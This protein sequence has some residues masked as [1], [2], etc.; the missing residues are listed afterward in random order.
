MN[1]TQP[2]LLLGGRFCT[3]DPGRPWAEAVVIRGDRIAFVGGEADAR[4]VAGPNAA[5]RRMGGR[6]VLPGL[7]DA[8]THPGLVTGSRDVFRLPVGG[9]P[10]EVVEAVAEAAA[11]HPDS[12]ALFGGYWPI[13]AFGLDGPRRELLDA[14]VPDRPVILFDDSGHSQWCNSAALRALGI[15]AS[16]P[17]PAPGLSEFKRDPGGWPTGWTKEFSLQARLGRL[18]FNQAA[19]PAELLAFLEDLVGCGVVALLDGGSQDAEPAVYAALADLDREGRLPLRYEGAVHVTQ[20][21]QLPGVVSRLDDLRRRVAG[22]RLRIDTVKLVL[23]GVTEVGTAA[24][25][26]PY[27]DGPASSG[28]TLVDGATLEEL[29]LALHRRAANLH[30]HTVG[31][32][33]VRLALDATER[34]QAAV[35]GRLAGTVTLSHIEVI[36]PADLPRFA[37][38]G[39]VAN[40]TPH[41]YGGYFHGAE[42]W[43]GAER[44]E[45]MYQVRT[46]TE[47]GATVA[48]SS[49]I[50]DHAEW[51]AGRANPFLGMQIGHTRREPGAPG[52]PRPR[53]E[54]GASREDLVRGYTLH[55]ARQLG[56]EA[57]LG[58]IAPCKRADLVVLDRDVFTI[59]AEE[60]HA[61]RPV[62]VLLAGQVVRGSLD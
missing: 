25:L 37:A 57:E 17:D 15:D 12:R 22:D 5:V 30:L 56:L 9:T 51:T 18:G 1:P 52:P 16:T 21:S 45:R 27:M 50:T 54:E 13:A 55:A 32:A 8:H 7:I 36:D 40:F 11:A 59:P 43:L 39:V 48:F 58:S 29:L 53:E 20:P 19:N 26:E 34:A 33:A 28:A 6:V 46:V 62:A 4:A 2:E 41:W 35:G 38:L 10:S 31:D 24:M 3:Q 44:F 23:D 42:R 61:V 47:T 49:D 14:V 60:I